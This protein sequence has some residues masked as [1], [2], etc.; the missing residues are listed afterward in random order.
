MARLTLLAGTAALLAAFALPTIATAQSDLAAQ[1][2]IDRLKPSAGSGT[3]GIRIP[4]DSPAPTQVVAPAPVWSA[5]AAARAPAP[6]TPAPTAAPTQTAAG[7]PTA[8]RPAAPRETT[9]DAPS[10]S[11]T[12]TFAS[13]SATLTPEA[14]RAL[15]PLGQALASPELA[16]YRF[17]IEGH[18]DTV[19]DAAVNQALSERRAAAVKDYLSRVYGVDAGRLVAVGFGSSQLLVQTPPQVNESR[20]RRVQVVNIGN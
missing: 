9:A 18:T 7:R 13:G 10:V 3:R 12:V 20:N 2:L 19:G 16:P 14:E 5:P 15:A 17:R 6:A 1:S 11:I 8:A 4:G